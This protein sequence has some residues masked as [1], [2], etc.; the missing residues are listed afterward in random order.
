MCYLLPD[1]DHQYPHKISTRSGACLRLLCEYLWP[2]PSVD[3]IISDAKAG[4]QWTHVEDNK[5]LVEVRPPTGD[6]IFVILR[7]EEPRDCVAPALF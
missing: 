2:A 4:V 3:G 5:D 7:V 6:R 1:L